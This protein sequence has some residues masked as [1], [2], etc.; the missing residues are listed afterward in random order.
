MY[1]IS[2]DS[3]IEWQVFNVFEIEESLKCNHNGELH[4]F[5]GGGNLTSMNCLPQ[6]TIEPSAFNVKISAL[7]TLGTHQEMVVGYITLI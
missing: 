4:L 1:L 5:I 7:N 6:T 3:S 2:C